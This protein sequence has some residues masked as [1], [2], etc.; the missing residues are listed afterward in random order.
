MADSDSPT[1]LPCA[2]KLAYETLAE[3]NAAKTTNAWRYA[4]PNLKAYKCRYC[5]LYHLATDHK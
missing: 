3:A 1:V 4:K 2:D 5:S